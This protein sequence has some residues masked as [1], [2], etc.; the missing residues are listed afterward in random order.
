MLFA[1]ESF[2]L[3][4]E[5][6]EHGHRDRSLASE[7]L[8]LGVIRKWLVEHHGLE[9]LY[10]LRV[11]PDGR[12]PMF[13][14]SLTTHGEPVWEPTEAGEEKMRQ[15]LEHLAPVVEAGLDDNR[16]WID[17]TFAPNDSGEPVVLDRM[18]FN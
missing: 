5:C 8:H 3:L 7:D 4:I 10:M 6:D 1:F 13:A 15:V 2:A 9:R 12:A 11:N 18:F 17:A 16:A 14:R